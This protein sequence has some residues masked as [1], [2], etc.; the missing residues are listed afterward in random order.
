MDNL[1]VHNAK[2]VEEE[3]ER[4]FEKRLLPTYSCALNP[5]ERIW[6]VVKQTWR[7]TV[8]LYCM[9]QDSVEDRLQAARQR[10]LQIVESI[11]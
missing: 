9:Q 4:H 2:I 11:E 1:S 6:S 8:H 5:I 3:F 7:K 10:I